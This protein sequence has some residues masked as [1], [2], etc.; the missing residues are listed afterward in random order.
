MVGQL[1]VPAIAAQPAGAGAG[2]GRGSDTPE[3]T[4]EAA[5][6]FE[7]LLIAQ[8]LRSVRESSGGWLGSG[9]DSAGEC[10]SGYAEEQFAALLSQRGGLGLANLIAAGLEAKTTSPQ[11]AAK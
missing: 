1:S 9:G 5:R 2:T 11:G 7:A 6:Q 3:S 4:R 10:A 8:I